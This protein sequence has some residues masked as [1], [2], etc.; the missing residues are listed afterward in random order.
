MATRY[1]YNGEYAIKFDSPIYEHKESVELYDCLNWKMLDTTDYSVN[2]LAEIAWEV[3][4][5]GRHISEEEFNN[6]INKKRD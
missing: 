5:S 6:L 3:S 4:A 1:E 2:E